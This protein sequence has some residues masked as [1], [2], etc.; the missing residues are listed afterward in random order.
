M[1][2]KQDIEDTIKNK[3][4][5]IKIDY[6]NRYLKQVDSLEMKRFILLHLAAANENKGLLHDAIRNVSAAGDVSLTFREKRDLYMKEV[7][8]WIKLGDFMMA[9]KAFHKSL[10]YGNDIEKMEMQELYENTFRAIGKSYMDQEKF[11]KALEVYEKVFSI[12]KVNLRKNEV[13]DKLL[14]LYGKLG[15][16]KEYDRLK[17]VVF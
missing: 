10:G 16:G 15:R 14:E 12:T 11:R 1:V 3:D 5:F 7:S 9:E 2:T 17:N 6:L 13:K 8:L 4:D